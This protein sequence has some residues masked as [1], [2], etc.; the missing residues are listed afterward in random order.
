MAALVLELL[1]ALVRA[2]LT[3]MA[4]WLMAKGLVT[5]EQVGRMVEPFTAGIVLM[6]ATVAWSLYAKY[7][8]RVQLNTALASP[9]STLQEVQAAIKDGTQAPAAARPDEVPVLTRTL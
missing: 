2:A 3:T 1:G 6:I 5:S 9:P 8:G 7:K 4:G